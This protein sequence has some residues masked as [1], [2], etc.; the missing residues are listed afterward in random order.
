MRAHD[1][2]VGF[3]A[4]QEARLC[5]LEAHEHRE[6][7]GDQEQEERRD[8]VLDPDHLVVGC[9]TEV[10]TPV[11]GGAVRSVLLFLIDLAARRPGEPHPEGADA[12]QKA[13]QREQ[14]GEAE[15][16]AVAYQQA[17]VIGQGQGADANG[18][19][20]DGTQH[21]PEEPRSQ[22]AAHWGT[23]EPAGD[24]EPPGD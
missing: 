21:G 2:V 11:A 6:G 12:G 19:A 4:E 20:Q 23:P 10:A 9:E 1:R 3:L 7:P 14:V 13:E 24:S 5:Q 18:A 17:S 15:E 16:L 22:D 8:E